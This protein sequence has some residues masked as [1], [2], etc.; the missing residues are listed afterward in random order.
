MYVV[1]MYKYIILRL[2]FTKTG[3]FLFRKL[4]STEN[5]N[6]PNTFRFSYY[7]SDF[8]FFLPSSLFVSYTSGY[9]KEVRT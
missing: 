9:I 6:S 1:C 4:Y 3:V 7:V 8:I 5:P 2:W